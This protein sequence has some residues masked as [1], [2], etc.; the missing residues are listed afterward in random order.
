M[1]ID[2]TEGKRIEIHERQVRRMF[3]PAA[4]LVVVA[5]LTVVL[6]LGWVFLY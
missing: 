6:V 3:H 1:A 5:L 2:A 4:W